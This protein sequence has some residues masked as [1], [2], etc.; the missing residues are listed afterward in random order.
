MHMLADARRLVSWHNGRKIVL[1]FR[2]SS[3]LGAVAIAVYV[4]QTSVI[5]LPDFDDRCGNCFA[6][7]AEDLAGNDQRHAG[8]A[9]GTQRVRARSAP[10][11]EWTQLSRGRQ[12]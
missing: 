1:P 3:Q 5:R 8:I 2:A 10:F 4:V 7:C 9:G 6:A 11:V 12:A